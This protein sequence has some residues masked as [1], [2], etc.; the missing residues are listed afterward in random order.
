M[1]GAMIREWLAKF[2]R[3]PE[4]ELWVPGRR[5]FLFMS[6]AAMAGA[7]LAPPGLPVIENVGPLSFTPTDLATSDWVVRETARHFVNALKGVKSFNR[8]Y[9]D[10]Y[11]LPES[12]IDV[13]LGAEVNWLRK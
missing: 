2:E 13:M 6:G 5:K 8:Q 10:A 9:S 12:R 1:W 4:R 11:S 7:V 3:D